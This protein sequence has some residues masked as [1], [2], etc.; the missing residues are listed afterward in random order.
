MD[1]PRAKAVPDHHDATT[2]FDCRMM[3][4]YKMVSFTAEVKGWCF[5]LLFVRQQTVSQKILG[6]IVKLW[7]NFKNIFDIVVIGYCFFTKRLQ[8]GV[9]YEISEKQQSPWK[10][11]FKLNS[12]PGP[13]LFLLFLSLDF[14]LLSFWALAFL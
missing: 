14:F 8:S 10:S 13:H 1:P 7:L 4:F 2:V 12:L 6:K 9:L 5:H 3:V 11:L